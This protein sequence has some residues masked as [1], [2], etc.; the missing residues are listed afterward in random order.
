M[1]LELCRCHDRH[2]LTTS[3]VR[4]GCQPAGRQVAA[5]LRTPVRQDRRPGLGGPPPVRGAARTPGM[6]AR[7]EIRRPVN[8]AQVARRRRR[9]GGPPRAR[10][11]TMGLRRTGARL[12][13]FRPAPAGRGV[14]QTT[15]G[16]T[17]PPGG[18]HLAAH[19]ARGRRAHR[20]L[21]GRTVQ[22]Q[23]AARRGARAGPAELP[24][25]QRGSNVSRRG[26]VCRERHR[27][28]RRPGA[29]PRSPR[30]RRTPAPS[31]ADRLTPCRPPDSPRGGFTTSR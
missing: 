7:A 27:S 15:V 13:R 24:G 30:C 12:Q 8:R 16:P 29:G 10:P 25:R 11:R 3:M 2:A 6:N 28:R 21:G 22:W 9:R 26:G 5:C 19:R 4:W 20:R 14:R 18:G 31:S 1:G 17:T 23:Q